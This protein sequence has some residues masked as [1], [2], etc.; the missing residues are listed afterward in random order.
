LAEPYRRARSANE[1]TDPVSCRRRG[2]GSLALLM[3]KKTN[4]RKLKARK[5]KANHGSKP[6]AGR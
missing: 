1:A 6:N 5:N 2:T 4:K 3:S